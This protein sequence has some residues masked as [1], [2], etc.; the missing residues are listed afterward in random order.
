MKDK[1]FTVKVKGIDV[2]ITAEED[3]EAR[4]M[5]RMS[6]AD[7]GRCG[8]GVRIG[9]LTGKQRKW[10]GESSRDARLTVPS[11]SAQDVC[12]KLAE[13]ALESVVV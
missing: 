9:Y 3:G 13:L 12:K 6:K 4:Y 8:V 1:K 10:V 11:D 2:Q 5:V 7:S